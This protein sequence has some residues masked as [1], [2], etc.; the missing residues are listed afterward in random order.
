MWRRAGAPRF[1]ANRNPGLHLV[2]APR[3]GHRVEIGA[4]NKSRAAKEM[5]EQDIGAFGLIF[6]DFGAGF[7]AHLIGAHR[8]EPEGQRFSRSAAV[9]CGHP[10]Q[11]AR[12]P[13]SCSMC[14]SSRTRRCFRTDSNVCILTRSSECGEWCTSTSPTIAVMRPS[15][16]SRRRSRQS[17]ART[18][19][20]S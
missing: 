14:P 8:G 10:A 2:L 1:F 16:T 5:G 6:D 12:A 9:S 15:L 7:G 4:G 18:Y 13:R 3:F 11:S 20:E 19:P 17:R